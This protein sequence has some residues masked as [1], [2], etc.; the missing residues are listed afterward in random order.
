[1]KIK[2][3]KG[4]PTPRKNPGNRWGRG[5][6]MAS[7]L[8]TMDIGDSFLVPYHKL[9]NIYQLCKRNGWKVKVQVQEK[10][11]GK[12]RAVRVWKILANTPGKE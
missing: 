10:D 1:M 11:I 3:E 5:G 7:A 2:I 9:S 4:I 8:R 12:L 6:S